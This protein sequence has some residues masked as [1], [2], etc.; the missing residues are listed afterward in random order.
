MIRDRS[1][2]VTGGGSGVSGAV[3]AGRLVRPVPLAVVAAH[4]LGRRTPRLELAQR[5]GPVARHRRVLR[6]L[7]DRSADPGVGRA[8][9]L[10]AEQQL[11]RV[12]VFARGA[13][14]SRPR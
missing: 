4:R 7:L 3:R 6:A 8:P 12:G 14:L 2:L 1:V 13:N 5:G 9:Q 10:A 11:A